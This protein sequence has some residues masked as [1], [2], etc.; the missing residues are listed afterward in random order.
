MPYDRE[1]SAMA[2]IA[3]ATETAPAASA[4]VPGW[5]VG[6]GA[7]STVIA[8]AALAL[9]VVSLAGV[10]AYAAVRLAALTLAALALACGG[11]AVV[12]RVAVGRLADRLALLNSA[13]ESSDDAHLLV[14]PDGTAAYANAAFGHRFGA[15]RRPLESLAQRL[16][17]DEEAAREFAR[18][19]RDVAAS[20][21]AAGQIALASG[22]ASPSWLAVAAHRLSGQDGHT[23]WR[24]ADITARH[25]MEQVI[26]DE[27]AKLA[28]F[29]DHAPIGFYSVDGDGR[30]R[31][32]NQ[33]LA[34]WLG[35]DAGALVESGA[36]LEEFLAAPAPPGTPAHAPF[37][38][39]EGESRGEVV[40]R[41]RQGRVLNARVT[42][43]VVRDA[44]ALRTRSVVQDLTREREWEEALRLSRQRF[45][46]F[47]ANAPVGIALVDRDGRLEEANRALCELFG[48]APS[49]LIGKTV[50]SL[51]DAAD[52]AALAAPIAAAAAGTPVAGGVEIR[53]HGARDKS[54]AVFV[55]RLEGAEDGAGGLILHFIDTTEQK[56]L[57]AQFAQSQKMQ[58]VGQLA[59]GVAHDFNNLL[60]A[61]IGFCDLLLLRF[62][63][64]D[65]A[66]ADIMQIK[67]NAN[68]AANLVRQLLAFSRQQSLQPRILSI[69]DVLAELSHLLRRLIGENIELKVVH[70]RDLGR[71][72]VD[73]GQL[74]QVIINLAVNARDAMAA[75]G[76]L[77]IRTANVAFDAPLRR[78]HELITPG[79]YVQIEVR[80][81]GIGIP[82][83]NLERIFEPF[84]S[85]KEVGSGTGLGLSTVYGIVKQTGGFIFVESEPAQGA[86]FVILLPRLEGAAAEEAGAAVRTESGEA[87]AGRDL[88]GAGTVLLV[89]DEDPVRLFSARALRNKGYKVVEARSGEAALDIITAGQERIDLLIS[90]VVMP[91]M[92]GPSLI[93]EVRRLHPEMKVIFISGYAE[94]AFR[95]RL[96][97]DSDIHFLPKPFSLKQLAGK[98][99]EVMLA[100]GA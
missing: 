29:I 42:Q 69:T 5:V 22:G 59:G 87:Q 33:A 82:K 44:A 19:G 52:A 50:V 21:A 31:F 95:N 76:T 98:V 86:A 15:G 78:G 81:T 10:G 16:A 17:H 72:K 13:L 37:E 74:E 90:D 93:K 25:E 23:L 94:D 6:L 2:S 61:M 45:R 100:G 35:A 64:G 27:Q 43:S 55:S 80:D 4:Y 60:T 62:R 40:L 79:A 49:E 75:G 56:S 32:V 51:L 28:D 34:E 70:G 24:F 39:S 68:R 54:A 67:Q 73:Q 48:F 83:E 84:F 14:A 1:R 36:R 58:A 41:G 71:V 92:D 88:T 97:N 91:R 20:G 96:G 89:E 46:R 12:A 38:G 26:H 66:F 30:F 47:F 65:P 57:E 63:L 53:L 3:A 7:A 11:A 85:T 18:L 77:T 9:A 99:K 8:L